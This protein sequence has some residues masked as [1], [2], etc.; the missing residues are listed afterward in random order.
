MSVGL[1]THYQ[2]R[3][4]HISHEVSRLPRDAGNT[5][6]LLGDVHVEGNPVKEMLGSHVINMGIQEDQ[7]GADCGGIKDRL[8]LLPMA[9]PAHVI[10][11]AG[12]N[13]LREGRNPLKIEQCFVELINQVKRQAPGA[14]IHLAEIPPTREKYGKLMHEIAVMNAILEEL[15]ENLGLE[16][17][18]LFSMLED[19]E[20]Q[21]CQD[22][23]E[24]GYYLNDTGFDRIN[25]MLERHL[26]SGDSY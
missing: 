19:D 2:L 20:G 6:V 26:E 24:D 11:M 22:C 1:P 8:W 4:D 17:V 23:S 9:R 12:L 5:V 3:L 15:A 14:K 10:I 7:L 18:D 21:L 13:D 25:T 16:L